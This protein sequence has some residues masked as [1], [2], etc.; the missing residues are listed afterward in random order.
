M[1]I[2]LQIWCTEQEGDGKR[3]RKSKKGPRSFSLVG[4]RKAFNV[5]DNEHTGKVVA[6]E[7]DADAYRSYHID[8]EIKT[9]ATSLIK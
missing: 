3:R 9:Y 2:Q 7:N 5:I 4:V 6:E 1:S 8:A